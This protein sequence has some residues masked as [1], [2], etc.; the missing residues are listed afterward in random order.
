VALA[1]SSRRQTAA[2]LPLN[3][4]AVKAST[5]DGHTGD[6]ATSCPVQ[7]ERRLLQESAEQSCTDHGVLDA[8]LGH[9]CDGERC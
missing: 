2:G 8:T 7:I 6:N 4:S 1:A 9:S 3:G 5:C